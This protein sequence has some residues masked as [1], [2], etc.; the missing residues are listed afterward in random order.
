M[1]LR[2]AI[3]DFLKN[4]PIQQGYFCKM[5]R[6]LDGMEA[7]DRKA[8][9]GLV[10]N[11]AISAAAISRLLADHGFDAKPANIMKHRRRGESNGCRCRK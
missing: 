3:E 10:D 2:D 11:R 8:V 1:R 4:P 5:S 6:I 9:L 7:D